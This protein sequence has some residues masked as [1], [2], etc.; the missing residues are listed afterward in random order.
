MYCRLCSSKRVAATPPER[1][2]SVSDASLWREVIAKS[3]AAGPPLSHAGRYTSA[4]RRRFELEGSSGRGGSK[5]ARTSV[6]PNPAPDAYRPTKLRAAFRRAIRS[7]SLAHILAWWPFVSITTSQLGRKASSAYTSMRSRHLVSVTKSSGS[8]FSFKGFE[9]ITVRNPPAPA[10]TSDWS[11]AWS[12]KLTDACRKECP[13]RS[14]ALDSF[15]WTA[16]EAVSGVYHCSVA[17]QHRLLS[18]KVAK[19]REWSS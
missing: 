9:G 2:A 4:G 14:I 12:L 10:S 18:T 3:K 7:P 8:Q 13:L 1:A 17:F 5:L 19:V 6:G 16:F 15:C 11:V